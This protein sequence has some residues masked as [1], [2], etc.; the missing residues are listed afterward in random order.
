MIKY[1]TGFVRSKPPV[2]DNINARDGHKGQNR[3]R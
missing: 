2:F 3:E 1:R